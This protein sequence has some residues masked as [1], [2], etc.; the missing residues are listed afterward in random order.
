MVLSLDDQKPVVPQSS[1]STA[2]VQLCEVLSSIVSV[3]ARLEQVAESS[4]ES[5]SSRRGS[6]TIV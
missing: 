3:C 5:V 4:D 2:V 1:R 6:H